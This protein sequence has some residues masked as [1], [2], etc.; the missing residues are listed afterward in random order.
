MT[1]NSNSGPTIETAMISTEE[2]ARAIKCEAASI[3][4]RYSTTGTYYG[5]RPT[6]LPNRRLLWP[7]NAVEQLIKG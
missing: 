6:K 1:P 5:I 7:T 3:R 2:F 4:K